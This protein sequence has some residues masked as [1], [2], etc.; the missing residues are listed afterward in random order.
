[1]KIQLQMRL[2]RKSAAHVW[3]RFITDSL[4]LASKSRRSHRNEVLGNGC[5]FSDP[6]SC[7]WVEES[8][9]AGDWFLVVLKLQF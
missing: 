6:L 9:L 5:I 1:M 8:G 3:V 7:V 4:S 2:E